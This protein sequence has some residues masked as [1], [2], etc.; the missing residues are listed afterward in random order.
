M[1]GRSR[2]DVN[3]RLCQGSLG[4]GSL[5]CGQVT[6][7]TNSYELIVSGVV[8]IATQIREHPAE[9]LDLRIANL[10]GIE[11]SGTDKRLKL[12]FPGSEHGKRSQVV[13]N[14]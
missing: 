13:K 12:T 7:F 9:T 14:G 4:V 6:S 1:L 2:L 5:Q 8:R 11:V 10:V 3:L